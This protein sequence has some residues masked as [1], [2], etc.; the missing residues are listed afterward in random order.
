MRIDVYDFTGKLLKT[1]SDEEKNINTYQIKL[2]S[3][4]FSSGYHLIDN[5]LND[6][7]KRI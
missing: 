3:D 7:Q 1:V 6:I 4:N 2:N 5:Q